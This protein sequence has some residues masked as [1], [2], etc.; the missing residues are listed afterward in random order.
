MMIVMTPMS[1]LHLMLQ[2]STGSSTCV[3]F[4]YEFGC[5]KNQCTIYLG[6]GNSQ[7]CIKFSKIYLFSSLFD[8]KIPFR[9]PAGWVDF[10]VEDT[11]HTVL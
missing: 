5:A 1:T 7:F 6:G 2:L 9:I 11:T 3:L 10:F 4:M 8:V